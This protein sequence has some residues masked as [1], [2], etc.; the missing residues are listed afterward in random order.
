MRTFSKSVISKIFFG[1]VT[2]LNLDLVVSTT[3]SNSNS[4]LKLFNTE[5]SLVKTT[6][7]EGG[8]LPCYWD[9]LVQQCSRVGDFPVCLGI[10]GEPYT[11]LCEGGIIIEG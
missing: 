3:N 4:D 9:V 10:C 5:V 1:V 11:L 7:A 2:L 8:C 6:S